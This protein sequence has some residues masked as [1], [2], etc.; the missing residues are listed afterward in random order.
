[1]SITYDTVSYASAIP[2]ANLIFNEGF[3]FQQTKSIAAFTK[4]NL[5]ITMEVHKWSRL[6][7][8]TKFIKKSRS[9]TSYLKDAWGCKNLMPWWGCLSKVQDSR[10]VLAQT[11]SVAVIFNTDVLLPE[12]EVSVEH[13]EW[14]PWYFRQK[15]CA[16]LKHFMLVG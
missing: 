11:C 1:M 9:N 16:W 13:V 4:M 14:N 3:A 2:R 6:S 5:E 8:K 15:D 12:T 10:S 7:R